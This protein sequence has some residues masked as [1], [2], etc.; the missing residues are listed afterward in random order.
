MGVL[1]LAGKFLNGRMEAQDLYQDGEEWEV[2]RLQIISFRILYSWL[3]SCGHYLFIWFL[4]CKLMKFFKKFKDIIGIY[5]TDNACKDI[6]LDM[7]FI[8]WIS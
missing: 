1:G 8:I 6:R 2:D 5:V 4:S 7:S 3:V